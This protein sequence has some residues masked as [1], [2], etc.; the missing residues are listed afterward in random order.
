MTIIEHNLIKLIS[1]SFR[2]ELRHGIQSEGF[3]I[4]VC[5]IKFRHFKL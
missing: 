2:F 1:K 5:V 3:K 4:F